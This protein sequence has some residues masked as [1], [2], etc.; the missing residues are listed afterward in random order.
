[1]T[2][3]EK[4]AVL[5]AAL[6]TIREATFAE[7][8]LETDPKFGFRASRDACPLCRRASTAANLKSS[9]AL[10]QV[11]AARALRDTQEEA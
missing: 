5:T 6:E 4:V 11:E 8:Q 9:W 1:M 3:E 7:F 10:I 2:S